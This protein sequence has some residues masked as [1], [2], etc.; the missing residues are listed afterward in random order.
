MSLRAFASRLRLGR[1]QGAVSQTGRAVT[2]KPD[3][4]RGPTKPPWDDPEIW[5]EAAANWEREAYQDHI[6]EAG[7]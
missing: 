5:K 4:W 3:N 2:P 1:S 6:M 7:F